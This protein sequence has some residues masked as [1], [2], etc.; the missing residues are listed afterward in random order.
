MLHR[1][2]EM[3]AVLDTDYGGKPAYPCEGK[4]GKMVTLNHWA[5][6]TTFMLHGKPS[7]KLNVIKFITTYRYVACHGI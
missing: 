6:I 2:R 1:L 5:N 7:L 4:R 3:T